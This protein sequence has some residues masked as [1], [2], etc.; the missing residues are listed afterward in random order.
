[1]SVARPRLSQLAL[2]PRH[3]ECV[4]SVVW[5]ALLMLSADP[6]DGS[7]PELNRRLYECILLANRAR[8][9]RGDTFLDVPV[10]WE[11]RN[12]PTPSTMGGSAEQKI[13]DFQCGY[14]DHQSADPLHSGRFFV[15]E[16]KRLGPTSSAGWNFVAHYVTDGVARFIDINWQYGKL[17]DSGAMIGYLQGVSAVEVLRE[18]NAVV[19]NLGIPEL[20]ATYA[21]AAP[22]HQLEHTVARNFPHSPFRIVHSW[23]E[24][25]EPA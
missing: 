23:V 18:V 16:C 1:M 24:R 2:W 8:H 3:V 14:I 7:E 15:I 13:P 6:L 22:L 12:Q 21:S 9:D 4:L 19:A 25:G 10:M 5:D 17:V 11:S 20:Q